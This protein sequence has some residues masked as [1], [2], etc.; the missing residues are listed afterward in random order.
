MRCIELKRVFAQSKFDPDYAYCEIIGNIGNLLI[1]E[2]K[3]F[4]CSGP[5]CKE[6]A[7]VQSSDYKRVMSLDLIHV[8]KNV[9]KVRMV[10]VGR[11]YQGHDLAPRVYAFLVKNTEMILRTAGLQSPGGSNI[12]YKLAKDS[13]LIV[14][15]W[16]GS[17]QYHIE[18]DDSLDEL[19]CDESDLFGSRV[20]LS[21]ERNF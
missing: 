1:W 15:G 12:W 20:E 6:I 17:H 21:V 7:V 19:V 11:K 3:V 2:E 16:F 13:E 5:R 14:R 18:V 8:R 10:S 4:N 9:W